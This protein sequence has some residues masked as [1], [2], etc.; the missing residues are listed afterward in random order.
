VHLIGGGAFLYANVEQNTTAAVKL[1]IIF[2]TNK[3][4]HGTFVFGGDAV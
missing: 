3:N 2:N 4:T 1:A